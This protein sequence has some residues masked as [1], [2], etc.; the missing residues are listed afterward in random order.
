VV[1]GI[2]GVVVF[3]AMLDRHWEIHPWRYDR[4]RIAEWLRLHTEPDTVAGSWWAGTIGYYSERKIVN[5]D[6]LVNDTRFLSHLRAGTESKYLL[7]ERIDLLVDYFPADPRVS[8]EVDSSPAQSAKIRVIADLKRAG[9]DVRI[10]WFAPDPVQEKSG[11]A[12][13]YLVE[14]Q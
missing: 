6:G 14:I 1:V 7:E 11:G 5:L 3:P 4:F 13:V 9:K 8:D 10:V 12:G 2:A